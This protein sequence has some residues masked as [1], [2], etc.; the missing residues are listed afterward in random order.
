MKDFESL[1]SSSF[2]LFPRSTLTNFLGVSQATAEER[3]KKKKL[4]DYHGRLECLI[5]KKRTTTLLLSKS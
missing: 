3:K 4:T 1:L 2:L 5:T